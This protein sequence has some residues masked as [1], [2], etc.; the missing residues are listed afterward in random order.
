MTQ[1]SAAQT[2]KS[3]TSDGSK[4]LYGGKGTRR[5]TVR[6]IALAKEAGRSRCSPP[7]TR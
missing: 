5:I 2:A 4:A 3:G 7:T 1:L 6:Y